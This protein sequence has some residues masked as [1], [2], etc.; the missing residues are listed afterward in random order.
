MLFFKKTSYIYFPDKT[1]FYTCSYFTDMQKIKHNST[2]M[3]YK[4]N[5]KELV[6]LYHGNAG[7]ACDRTLYASYFDGHNISYILVEYAGYAGDDKK[8]SRELIL[9]DVDNVINL[10]ETLD[11]DK[12]IILGESVGAG[13]ATHH[14]A[15]KEPDKIILISPFTRLSDI[16]RIHYPFYPAKFLLDEDYDNVE[17]L[18]HYEGALLIISGQ[19]DRIIPYSMSEELYNIAKLASHKE[20]MPV[21]GAEHNDLF[22]HDE[23]FEKII[24]FVLK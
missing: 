19:N 5:G 2:R 15:L 23:V 24:E 4:Q 12:L 18:S 14:A 20:L 17:P 3:Y 9:E 22:I 16:A 10:L 13:V 7:S 1:D 11:Y 6:V 8:P 21:P